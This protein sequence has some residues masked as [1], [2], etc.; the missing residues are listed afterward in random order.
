MSCF[1]RDQVSK[2]KAPLLLPSLESGVL[3]QGLVTISAG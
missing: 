2:V 3:T 1:T